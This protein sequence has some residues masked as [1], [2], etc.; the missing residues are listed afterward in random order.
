M[1]NIREDI[2]KVVAN[3]KAHAIYM[4][5]EDGDHALITGERAQEIINQLREEEDIV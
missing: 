5:F 1:E 2:V 3:F 4:E